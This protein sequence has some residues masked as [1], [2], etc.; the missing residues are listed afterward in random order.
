M[1]R[2]A[3]AGLIIAALVAAAIPVTTAQSQWAVEF[4]DWTS[5]SGNVAMGTLRGHGVT[6]S[7]SIVDPPPSS[8]LDGTQDVFARPVS[9]RRF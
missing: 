3:P 8:A 6:L 4:T 7:G 2:R 9:R 1:R 5:S